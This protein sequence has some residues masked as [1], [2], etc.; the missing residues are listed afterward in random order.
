MEETCF[1]LINIV[2]IQAGENNKSNHEF[3]IFNLCIKYFKINDHFRFLTFINSK[4]NFKNSFP[5]LTNRT[6]LLFP[7][8]NIF[9]R[10]FIKCKNS[11]LGMTRNETNSI[12]RV[13]NQHLSKIL[14]PFATDYGSS[15]WNSRTIFRSMKNW[16]GSEE[17]KI[18]IFNWLFGCLFFDVKEYLFI[19]H[20]MCYQW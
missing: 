6:F 16:I 11:K 19:F 13:M 7:N 8:F 10:E 1:C 12:I 17:F 3:S 5:F 15:F 20:L 4:F 14:N 18:T 9:F 2:L